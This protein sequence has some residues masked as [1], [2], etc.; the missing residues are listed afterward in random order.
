MLPCVA[1]FPLCLRIPPKLKLR[2]SPFS[3]LLPV[4]TWWQLP[5]YY[6]G[7][8]MYDI[9]AGTEGGNIGA[10][11]MGKTKTLDSFPML[12]KDGLVGGVV[13]YDGQS[14]RSCRFCLSRWLTIP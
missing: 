8:K 10:Y 4:Y 14:T 13:Y 3:I 2:F 6:A 7:C 9:L 1:F 5:Y 12:K 11:M